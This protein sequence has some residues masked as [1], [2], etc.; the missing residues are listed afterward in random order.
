[1]VPTVLDASL[2]RYGSATERLQFARD[3]VR[4]F[5]ED[6]FLKL[7]NHGIAS[8]I[9]ADLFAWVRSYYASSL[10]C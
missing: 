5:K 4:A 6:G 3:L 10:E 8:S 2:F 7:R 1:M 9:I